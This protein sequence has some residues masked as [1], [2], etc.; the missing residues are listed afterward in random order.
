MT[1]K[2]FFLILQ[3]AIGENVRLTHSLSHEE[4]EEMLDFAKKQALL[5]LAFE[6][7]KKLPKEQWPQGNI[8]LKWTMAT[9]Q[10]KRLNLRTTNAC[11]RLNDILSKEGFDTCILK[12]QAN[13]VY[14]DSLI[15]GVSLGMQRVCGDVDAWIWPKEKMQH[16]VKNIIDY[17]QRKNIL[18]SLCH[19][20]AEVKPIGGVPI[21]IHF[22]PSFL[23]T[24]WR[25]RYFQKLF[26]STKFEDVEID[27]CGLVKKL[28]VDYDL[29]FQMNHIYRH[30]LDEGVGMRQVFDFYVLLKEYNKEQSERLELM[31]KS[32]LIKHI[33]ACGMK[34]FASALMLV[35]QEMFDISND[36]LLC[37]ASKK[38]G[39]FLL[40]EMM[41]AGNFGHNDERMKALEVKKGRL[42]YQLQ[43]AQRRFKRNLRFLTSYPEE[44]ICEPFARVYH[45]VW[46]KF[47]LYRY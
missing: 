2:D 12:G 40:N 43:K 46:R 23:N 44:V 22:R 3:S 35:L 19:L 15:D 10:I 33:R 47:G 14:Y 30:L 17:C 38:H 1:I 24:P 13:H 18:L 20:H 21:E 7:V 45:F 41:T 31:N 27:K 6:G 32:E 37:N 39:T 25:N 9:E 34:R 16:P 42:S 28:R 29:I 11:L 26:Q 4:W 36:E 5:G 8:V